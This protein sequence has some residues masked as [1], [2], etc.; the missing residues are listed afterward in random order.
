MLYNMPTRRPKE[1]PS[2]VPLKVKYASSTNWEI[3]QVDRNIC[4]FLVGLPLYSMP[5]AITCVV[6]EGVRSAATSKFWI[7]G[8]GF[9]EDRDA[10]LQ[11][12]CEKFDATEVMPEATIDA[13]PFCLTLAKIAH[14]YA[15]A[16]L[17]LDGFFPFLTDAIKTRNLNNRADFIG[18]GKGDEPPSEQLHEVDFD[19]NVAV[20]SNVI[21]VRIRLFAVLGTPTYHVAVG[22]KR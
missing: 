18:G 3:I 16:Q 6:T 21:A 10:Q 12:L 5:D 7:R 11:W 20:N 1:R 4:P 22:Y 9:W 15:T 13:E 19:E 17:G 2:H 14:S 8:A